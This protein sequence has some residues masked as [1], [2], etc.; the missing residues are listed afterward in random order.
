LIL[1][2]ATST[3]PSLLRNRTLFSTAATLVTTAQTLARAAVFETL[4]FY[5]SNHPN[6]AQ[7]ESDLSEVLLC[8]KGSL[9]QILSDSS[10]QNQLGFLDFLSFLTSILHFP[11]IPSFFSTS[12]P[13]LADFYLENGS[14]A[15]I[16]VEMTLKLS[17]SLPPNSFYGDEIAPSLP[18][19]L[20]LSSHINKLPSSISSKILQSLEKSLPTVPLLR[21]NFLL[22]H[23]F[24]EETEE[25]FLKIAVYCL[26]SLGKESSDYERQIFEEPLW[27]NIKYYDFEWRHNSL[28]K[29]S[30]PLTPIFETL[31]SQIEEESASSI[32]SQHSGQPISS[33]GSQSQVASEGGFVRATIPNSFGSSARN[34]GF[35]TQLFLFRTGG[36]GGVGVEASRGGTG[37]A[38]KG[39]N[40]GNKGGI[41]E[42]IGSRNRRAD[43]DILFGNGSLL[44]K[45]LG[46]FQVP[47]AKR[48]EG[49]AGFLASNLLDFTQTSVNVEGRL[50]FAGEKRLGAKLTSQ[51]EIRSRQRRI[52]L[53]RQNEARK[54]Q[55]SAMRKYRIGELPDIEIKY[56]DL[57]DPLRLLS[58]SDLEFGSLIFSLLIVELYKSEDADQSSKNISYSRK[59]ERPK[60][61]DGRKEELIRGLEGILEKSKKYEHQLVNAVLRAMVELC[62]RFGVKWKTQIVRKAGEK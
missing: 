51:D 43:G 15:E 46:G 29:R 39:I 16:F 44:E 11:Q 27:E 22:K 26:L 45:G 6:R 4:K 1:K 40:L 62:R 21:L 18:I 19:L 10:P 35:A 2:E 60:E 13:I 49:M 41:G 34:E 50:R 61:D 14:Y 31:A 5:I 42:G 53:E 36:Y 33:L 28:L 23:V 17:T 32:P 59:R 52:F 9:S 56:K 58:H 57:L 7:S 30:Q 24:T 12:L 55:I 48:K 54:T 47:K 25:V 20:K 8:I 38:G 37:A 3:Y